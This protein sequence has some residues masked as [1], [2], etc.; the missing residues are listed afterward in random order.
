MELFKVC[1]L[2]TPDDLDIFMA[3]SAEVVYPRSQVSVYRTI[4][5][6]VKISFILEVLPKGGTVIQKS[7]GRLH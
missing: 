2:M 4:S 5:P 6:L 3:R 7:M 1:I